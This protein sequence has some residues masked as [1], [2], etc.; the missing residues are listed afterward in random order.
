[1]I[2]QYKVDEAILKSI[3]PYDT[4]MITQMAS[5][6]EGRFVDNTNASGKGHVL[7][8]GNGAMDDMRMQLHQ[9]WESEKKLQKR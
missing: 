9:K 6:P 4:P 5:I 3:E 8:T 2:R 1:M 7:G